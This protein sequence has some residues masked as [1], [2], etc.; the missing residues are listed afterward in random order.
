MIDQNLTDNTFVIK[1]SFFDHINMK[2]L[3]DKAKSFLKLYR[4][5]ENF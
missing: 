3:I 1:N 4:L 2:P 5:S